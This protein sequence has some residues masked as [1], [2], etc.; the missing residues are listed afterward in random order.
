MHEFALA[1]SI[2]KI[3]L[4]TAEAHHAVRVTKVDCRVGAMR[5]IVP[6]LLHTAFEACCTET[7][8]EGANLSIEI[9]PVTVTCVDCGAIRELETVQYQCPACDSAQISLEGGKAM[10]IISIDIDQEDDDGHSSPSERAGTQR[11]NGG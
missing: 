11:R 9:A 10:E 5:Q 7:I 3:A 2:L 1:H 6:S 8:A 4:E